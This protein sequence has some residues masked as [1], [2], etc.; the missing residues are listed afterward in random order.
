MFAEVPALLKRI[1]VIFLYILNEELIF[2]S[3]FPM[4][5]SL[6]AIASLSF[7]YCFR[8]LFGNS[9]TSVLQTSSSKLCINLCMFVYIFVCVCMCE[10]DCMLYMCLCVYV[11]YVYI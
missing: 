4:N 5:T 1:E 9:F 2:S 11:Y 6:L 8:S 3:V 10:Y 7:L